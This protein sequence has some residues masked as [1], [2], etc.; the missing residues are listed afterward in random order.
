[1]ESSWNMTLCKAKLPFGKGKSLTLNVSFTKGII[2]FQPGV[3]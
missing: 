2:L 3:S 1:M